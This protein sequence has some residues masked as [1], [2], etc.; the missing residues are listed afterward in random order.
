MAAVVTGALSAGGCYGLT[1]YEP[2][3]IDATDPTGV[4]LNITMDLPPIPE[5]PENMAGGDRAPGFQCE[6]PPDWYVP[7]VPAYLDGSLCGAEAAYAQFDV[8]EHGRYSVFLE[9]G[10]E[11]AFIALLGPGG[12]DLGEIG[13]GDPSITLELDPARYLL[14][15]T[16]ADPLSR[17]YEWFSV[18]VVLGEP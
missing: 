6:A 11:A 7:T 9:N 17:P 15:A 1:P 12:A 13:P 3:E 2:D 16:P 14:A 5:E 8:L 4:E 18:Q 10:A